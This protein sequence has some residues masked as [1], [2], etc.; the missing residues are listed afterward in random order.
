MTT[1]RSARRTTPAEDSIPQVP[2]S[3]PNWMPGGYHAHDFTLQAVIELQK[4]VGE[5]NA[6]VQALKGSVDGLKPKVDDLIKWKTLIIGG[7]V[8]LGVV[9]SVLAF[10]AVKLSDYVTIKQPSATATA[11]G[12]PPPAASK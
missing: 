6:N 2:Q 4:S 9:V 3:T 10:V 5:M 12:H 8:T 11:A 1:T 7:A